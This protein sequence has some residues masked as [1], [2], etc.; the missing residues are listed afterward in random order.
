MLQ[1]S[2]RQ[3]QISEKVLTIS[4]FLFCSRI[5]LKWGFLAPHLE[6]LDENLPTTNFPIT[7]NYLPVTTP[8]VIEIDRKTWSQWQWLVWTNDCHRLNQWRAAKIGGIISLFLPMVHVPCCGG[9]ACVLLWSLELCRWE[10]S[11]P[12]K[13]TH[14][15]QVEAEEPD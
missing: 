4:F 8:L 7:Q 5:S 10:S 6:F 1:L 13:A 9:K 11:T 2:N 12:G 15:G 3:L 14:A